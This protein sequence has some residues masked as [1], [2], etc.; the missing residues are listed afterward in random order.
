MNETPGD[1]AGP[2]TVA[3]TV[4]E[5]TAYMKRLIERDEVLAEVSVRGEIS[6]FTHHGSGHMYFSLKDDK[7]QLS[8]V[9]FR[10]AAS[11]LGFV[12]EAG[13]RVVAHGNISVYEPRGAYQIIVRAM[14]P[15][16]AGELAEALAK[17]RARLEAEGLFDPARK[18]E[19][20][21]LPQR[22]ALVTS[23]TG[24][25]VRDLVSV[26]SRR[27]PPAELLIVPTLV[28]GE[29]APESIVRSLQMASAAPG[30]DLIIA[31]R[32]GGS[33]EDLWAFNDE[34][35]AR[36][37]F[38][39]GVPVMSA[40]GHE[41]DF[42]IADEVADLRAPT[43]SAAGE[44]AVPDVR[45]LIAEL[46][47]LAN[48]AQA[49]LASGVSELRGRLERLSEGPALA[50]PAAMLEPLWQRV[51]EAA[52]DLE[53][54]VSRGLER[55]GARLGMAEGTLL[56]LD[57]TRVLERGYS[58]TRLATGNRDLVRSVEQAVADAALAITVADGEFGAR[59]VSGQLRVDFDDEQ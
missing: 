22:I 5:I 27:Y 8:A 21:R 54:A 9:C 6:N 15:D 50:R 24:A 29:G 16:G 31:G 34:R 25:A 12:P 42:T 1:R 17:L 20:P 46:N 56:A 43:P 38:A 30:V 11:R 44:L 13:Q 40:V 26:I 45:E 59:V 39:C 10:G 51:D 49:T 7:S 32:G 19:L 41:T 33:L 35:V 2:A 36:A 37:I 47:A 3:F 18:R 14:Q 58:I 4:S 52:D 55:A 48:R 23:P 28:Q 53:R 57:P